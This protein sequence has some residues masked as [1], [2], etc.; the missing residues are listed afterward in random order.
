MIGTNSGRM[1]SGE[2]ERWCAMH[3]EIFLQKAK[4]STD[5][6]TEEV[7]KKILKEVKKNV[8]RVKNE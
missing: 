6:K 4:S 5:K 3:S 2:E 7:F 8:K 1:D